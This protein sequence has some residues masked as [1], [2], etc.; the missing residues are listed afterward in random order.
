MTASQASPPQAPAPFAGLAPDVVL[1]ALAAVGFEGDGRLIQLNSFENR[2]YQVSLVDGTHVVTKFYRPARWTDEQIAEE[3]AFSQEALDAEIP[4]VAPL[5]LRHTAAGPAASGTVRSCP[6]APRTLAA[7]HGEAGH[8]R[9][10]VW[11]RRAGRPAELE[12]PEVL[13]RMGAC[14][15]RLHAVGATRPFAHR[16]RMDLEADTRLALDE[17]RQSQALPPDQSAAWE[18]IGTQVVAR[19]RADCQRV[20]ARSLRLH[21]DCHPGNLLWRDGPNLVDLDDSCTGPA[22]Q[23]LWMLLSGEASAARQQL[24]ALLEGYES[25]RPFDRRELALIDTLRLS[26][27]VRHNAWVARRWGDP[28]F[29]RAYPD[30]GSSSYWAQQVSA[31]R[32]Q[33]AA[34]IDD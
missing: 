31:L 15:G 32:D 25:F 26:R 1:D 3:H 4:V 34:C 33:L 6:A 18:A 7:Y 5:E 11:P 23:D 27:M 28:A 13:T 8:W 17:L 29:P 21:G 22:V 10:A 30:F 20:P 19:I 24:E 16:H 12:D 14:L 9:F 2:V